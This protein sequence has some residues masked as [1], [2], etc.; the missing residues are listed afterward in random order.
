MNPTTALKVWLRNWKS[1]WVK[2]DSKNVA[3]YK[4]SRRDRTRLTTIKE[5]YSS[6]SLFISQKAL[7]LKISHK[8]CIIISEVESLI[9]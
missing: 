5:I 7:L 3:G 4:S 9:F 1:D 6:S 2:K 8:L